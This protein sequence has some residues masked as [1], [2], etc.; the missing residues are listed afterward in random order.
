MHKKSVILALAL[1]LVGI[2]LLLQQFDVGIP[3]WNVTWPVFPFAGGLAI[4]G[5]YL[6]GKQRDSEHVFIGTAATLVGLFFFF[7]T[8]GPLEYRDLGTWW[9]IFVLIG[10]IAFVAQWAAARF[11]D[12]G[13]LFLGLVAL[14]FGGVALAL[15]L[16]LFGAQTAELLPKLWP[17]PL[18]LLGVLLL[19][20]GLLG[21]RS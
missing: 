15:K 9:P 8:L 3:G 21:R 4:L 1:I 11:R 17:A 20:R 18:V 6:F 14:A 7:I 19:L 10:G 13:A 12:W 5:G 2:Y 16:D